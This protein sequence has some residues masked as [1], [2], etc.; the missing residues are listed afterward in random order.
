MG[1]VDVRIVEAGRLSEEAAALV[2]TARAAC[3]WVVDD[4]DAWVVATRLGRAASVCGWRSDESV[5]VIGPVF[6]A[7]GIRRLGL[8][9]TVVGYAMQALRHRGVRHVEASV[10]AASPAARRTLACLRFVELGEDFGHPGEL[11]IRLR[12]GL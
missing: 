12:H 3:P 4:Q 7:P 1:L 8:G 2:A 5:G 10:P 6:T 9:R 11:L